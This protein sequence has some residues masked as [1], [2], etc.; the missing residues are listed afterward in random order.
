MFL[1]SGKNKIKTPITISTQK[2]YWRHSKKRQKLETKQANNH[3]EQM[4]QL[5]RKK[6]F[7]IFRLFLFIEKDLK[8]TTALK[9]KTLLI[10]DVLRLIF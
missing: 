1:Q 2:T 10:E 8:S 4:I 3:Y 6:P 7:G 5:P 9:C